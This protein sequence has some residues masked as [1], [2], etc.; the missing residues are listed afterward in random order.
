MA[1]YRRFE[2]LEIWQLARQLCQL[3]FSYT[4]QEKFSKDFAL[5]DQIRRSSGS[6]MDNI[7][8]PIAIGTNEVAPGSSSI[9]F[10]SQ[11][12]LQE[13]CNLSYTGQKTK[14]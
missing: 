4:L 11:R 3:I 8:V 13:K 2:D 9:F 7:A 10:Q 12:A 5:K 14:H 6:I 1:T